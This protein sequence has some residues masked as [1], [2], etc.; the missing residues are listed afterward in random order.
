M[1]TRAP[2]NGL[3]FQDIRIVKMS[4]NEFCL[5]SSRCLQKIDFELSFLLL[6]RIYFNNISHIIINY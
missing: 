5:V 6:T 2:E 1:K 4:G 3:Y